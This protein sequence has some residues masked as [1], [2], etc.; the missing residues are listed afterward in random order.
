MDWGVLLSS[1]G[2]KTEAKKLPGQQT[3]LE[4]L[5]T[6]ARRE[7]GEGRFASLVPAMHAS[8]QFNQN[9]R[10]TILDV[11]H[12][13]K[14][15]RIARRSAPAVSLLARGPRLRVRLTARSSRSEQGPCLT[16]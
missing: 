1:R 3:R 2:S 13:K 11:S 4:E 10:T 9:R 14:R 6:K 7:Q 8:G 15:G 12:S 5:A 16:L